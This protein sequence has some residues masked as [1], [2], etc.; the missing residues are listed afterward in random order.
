M[1][2]PQIKKK[3]YLFTTPATRNDLHVPPGFS[4]GKV[5]IA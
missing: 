2:T 4:P 3:G 5:G 1:K